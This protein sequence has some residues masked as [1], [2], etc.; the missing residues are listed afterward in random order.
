MEQ[1]SEE[2]F[3]RAQLTGYRCACVCSTYGG[4][5]QRWRSVESE[6]RKEA[7]LKH[8][9]EKIQQ[10]LESAR[11]QL[12]QLG[13]QDFACVSDA[14]AAAAQ[15][16]QGLRYHQLDQIEVVS[17]PYYTQAGRPRKGQAPDG[18]HYRL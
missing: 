9:E 10:H 16:N 5:K 2:A 11:K 4:I 18:Y 7:D 14:L 6:A 15:L 13:K 1:L 17:Q 3:D 12:K 8:L